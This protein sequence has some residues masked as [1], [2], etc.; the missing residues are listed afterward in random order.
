MIYV[1]RISSPLFSIIMISILT[2]H[3]IDVLS[4]RIIVM[5]HLILVTENIVVHVVLLGRLGHEYKRLH[6]TSHWL[7]IV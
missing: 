1:V 2:D 4:I 3:F 5:E 7:P 6:E